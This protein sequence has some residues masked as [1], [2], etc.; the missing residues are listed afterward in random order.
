MSGK[1]HIRTSKI[2]ATM[3]D[4]MSNT[5]ITTAMIGAMITTIA[6]MSTVTDVVIGKMTPKGGRTAT[7]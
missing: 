5:M 2:V 7:A 6:A 3:T 4:M 1:L